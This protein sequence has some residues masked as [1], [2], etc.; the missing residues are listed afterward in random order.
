MEML[1]AA[2]YGSILCPANST[3]FDLSG[4]PIHLLNSEN[5]P[6]STSVPPSYVVAYKLLISQNRKIKNL[7]G[8]PHLFPVFVLHCLMFN[9][10]HHCFIYF[11]QFLVI[12]D[13]ELNLDPITPFYPEAEVFYPFI[14][15]HCQLRV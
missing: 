6:G 3:Y 10:W 4:C 13:R 1:C 12:S 9:A 11:V 7:L 5:L 14:A 8:S 15:H 2:F